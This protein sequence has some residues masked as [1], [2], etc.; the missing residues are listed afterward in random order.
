MGHPRF[1]RLLSRI[2]SDYGMVLVLLLL[3]ACFSYVTWDEQHPTGVDAAE[4]LTA[5]ITREFSAGGRRPGGGPGTPGG[6]RF[7][8]LPEAPTGAAPD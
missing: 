2:L 7:R 8:R 1:D 6:R 3:G 4:Q 5:R